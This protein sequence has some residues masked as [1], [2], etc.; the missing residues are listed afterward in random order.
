MNRD[1]FGLVARLLLTVVLL[2]SASSVGQSLSADAHDMAGGANEQLEAAP[3]DI[4]KGRSSLSRT[5]DPLWVSSEAAT[6]PEGE[7][8]W[9][10]LGEKA[11]SVYESVA[12]QPPLPLDVV[13][14]MPEASGVFYETASDGEIISWLRYGPGSHE[15]PG[16]H[17]ESLRQVAETARGVYVGEVVGFEEGF[18]LG[19]V[20][21]LLRIRT[22]RVVLSSD[23]HRASDEFYLFWPQAKFSIGELNFWKDNPVYPDRP[24]PG[25]RVL[26]VADRRVPFDASR[27][28]ILPRAEGVFVEPADGG[29]RV[30]ER[31]PVP[32]GARAPATLDEV[33]AKLERL[34]EEQRRPR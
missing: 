27:K 3:L 25:A 16:G 10:L 17:L 13:D 34:I 22:E 28:L 19:D 26:V 23:E 20:G 32:S 30:S 6:T 18:L 24:V 1:T 5:S 8:D 11:R 31:A 21:S 4:L 7:V 29:V 33:A 9:A 2:L 14:R 15:D 12:E